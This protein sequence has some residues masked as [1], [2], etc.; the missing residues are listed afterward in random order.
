MKGLTGSTER[1]AAG[2]VQA[3]AKNIPVINN[4]E[5]Q[6]EEWEV[7]DSLLVGEN[8]HKVR[9]NREK[10]KAEANMATGF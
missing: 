1:Q 10:Q 6:G 3:K 9:A 2:L 5:S 4:N 8:K 7:T